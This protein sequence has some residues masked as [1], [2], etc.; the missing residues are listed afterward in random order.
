MDLA[1]GKYLLLT[2]FRKNGDG[3]PTPVWFAGEGRTAFVWT[4][5]ESGKV[6]RIRRSGD[7]LVGPCD[8]RGNPL[9]ESV[10]A[11][12]E[13]VDVAETDRVRERIIRKYGVIGRLTILGSKLRRGK[14]GTVGIKITLST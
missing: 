11:R 6:K 4:V 9:G 5:A 13:L 2:T 1:E 3:V 10:P 8:V 7:V 12:A 14:K